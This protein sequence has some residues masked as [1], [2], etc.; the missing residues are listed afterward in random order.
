MS[1]ESDIAGRIAKKGLRIIDKMLDEL[2]S[3]P[4]DDWS[5]THVRDVTDCVMAAVKVQAEERAQLEFEQSAGM[6]DLRRLLKQ[7]LAGL[8]AAEVSLIV[9]EAQE[10]RPQQEERHA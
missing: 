4:R 6:E 2:E 9:A 1:T 8:P 5:K 7:Y 3:V 10:A